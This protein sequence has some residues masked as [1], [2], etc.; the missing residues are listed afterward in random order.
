MQEQIAQLESSNQALSIKLRQAEQDGQHWRQ[1]L[2][3]FQTLVATHA[4]KPDASTDM[5]VLHNEVDFA[6][7]K[8]GIESEGG[9]A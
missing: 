4:S 6:L 2:V 5:L 9:A 3:E 7:S 1:Q 8:N